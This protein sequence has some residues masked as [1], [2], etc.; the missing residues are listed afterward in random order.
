VFDQ[1]IP[2]ICDKGLFV[3]DQHNPQIC[4]KG[5]FV[6]DQHIAVFTHAIS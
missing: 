5:L 4:D 3:F 1:H 6:F 2:Q